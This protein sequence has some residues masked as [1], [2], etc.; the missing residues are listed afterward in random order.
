MKLRGVSLMEAVVA[1]FILAG[2][3]LACFT[4]LV[5][6]FRYQFA[7]E[8]TNSAVLLAERTLV[9]IRSWASQPD[10]FDSDW[11]VYA[12][13]SV[14]MAEFPGL[15]ARVHVGDREDT[16]ANVKGTARVVEVLVFRDSHRVLALSGLMT[17]PPRRPRATDTLIVKPVTPT[18]TL[19]EDQVAEYRA[20]LY[21]VNDRPIPGVSFVFSQQGVAPTAG[22]GSLSLLL[23]DGATLTHSLPA[24]PGHD[25]GQLQVVARARY[26]GTD[27]Q[28]ISDPIELLPP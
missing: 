15:E 24:L 14:Q 3:S 5:Q 2:G 27:Y 4:L 19:A 16:N 1:I 26:R 20:A 12:N 17:C 11:S 9:S 25:P 18:T 10:H 7:S 21:D 28:G 13:Q 22:S 23:P 8:S 6:A